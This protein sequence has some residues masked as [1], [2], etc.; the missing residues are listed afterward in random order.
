[1]DK[2]QSPTRTS[3]AQAARARRRGWRKAFLYLVGGLI[4]GAIVWGLW[5]K[6]IAVDEA[7]VTRGPLSVSVL[8]EGKTRIR[9]R[10]VISPPVAGMLQRVELR[11]G[12]PIVAGVTVLA[13]IEA[14][15]SGFLDPK[16]G[17][18]R[19]RSTWG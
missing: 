7:R 17:G 10:Y 11:A 19:R 5:P 12:A 15:P 1:M 2:P 13:T 8:E 4:A 18:R 3:A 14:E 9:H 16:S 6:P